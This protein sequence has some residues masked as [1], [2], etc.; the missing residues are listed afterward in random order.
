MSSVASDDT[1]AWEAAQQVQ[2]TDEITPNMEELPVNRYG[3]R[4]Y[5]STP[6][7]Q[8]D[9]FQRDTLDVIR[10]ERA[11]RGEWVPNP[12][13]LPPGVDPAVLNGVKGV[14]QTLNT[15]LDVQPPRKQNQNSQVAKGHHPEWTDAR[16]TQQA[17][18]WG[19]YSP[20]TAASS[21]IHS[22]PFYASEIGNVSPT[23]RYYRGI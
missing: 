15:G 11:Q 9:N 5:T 12:L 17:S 2:T 8:L 21:L 16:R 4:I 14:D 20:T 18:F 1:A 3:N 6:G 13:D 22:P 10:R 7:P 19:P 23:L